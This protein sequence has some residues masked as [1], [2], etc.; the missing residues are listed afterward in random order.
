MLSR[1]DLTLRETIFEQLKTKS[2]I[3]KS[4]LDVRTILYKEPETRKFTKQSVLISK[5]EKS[6]ITWTDL[7]D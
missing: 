7:V 5:A 4:Y 6:H 2:D 3:K 1:K